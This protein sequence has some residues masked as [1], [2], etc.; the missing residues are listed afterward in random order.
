MKIIN[1][2]NEYIYDKKTSIHI[3]E[4]K[5]NIVNYIDID[6]FSNEKIVINYDKGKIIIDGK[7]LVVSKLINN[8]L[9]IRGEI[10]R[11]ELG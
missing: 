10:K 9:L 5:I 1:K 11:I 2:I 6:N 7:N 3:Y 8:E 4:N